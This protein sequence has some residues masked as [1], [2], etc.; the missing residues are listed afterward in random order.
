MKLIIHN[1]LIM[2]NTD[3]FR[4]VFFCIRTESAILPYSGKYGL[5]KIHILHILCSARHRRI[6][7]KF[8]D[9]G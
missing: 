2:Q 3:F 4:P 9:Y 1:A 6:F 5:R 7:V 8:Y